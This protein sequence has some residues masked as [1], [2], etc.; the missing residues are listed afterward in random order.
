MDEKKS[1]HHFF[2][3]FFFKPDIKFEAQTSNEET[4]LVLR[5]HPV[6]QI[7]FFIN[8]LVFFLF[9][10]LLNFILP[11]VMESKKIICLNIFCLAIIFNYLWFNFL[12]WYFTV[13]IVTNQRLIDVDFSSV[14]YKEVT[15]AN[16]NKVEDVTA[17]GGGF[18]ASFFNYGD[19]FVQTAGTESNIE[20]E[21]IPRPAD[22]AKVINS[23]I[24]N[25]KKK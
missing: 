15:Y 2:H 21:G 14:I 9:I 11:T 1:S 12:S 24:Q 3:S 25:N 10:F 8:S 23:L 19:I 17:K 7:P 5:A 22:V 18:M 4:I 6:T 20:Y 13:G 16:L